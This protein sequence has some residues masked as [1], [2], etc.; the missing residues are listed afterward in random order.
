MRLW[1]DCTADEKIERWLNVDRVLNELTPHEREEYW[2]MSVFGARTAC[3]TIACAAG[4]CE[5]DDWFRAQGLVGLY[6]AESSWMFEIVFYHKNIV[7][8]ALLDKATIDG[9][10]VPFST[11]VMRFFGDIGSGQIFL[12]SKPRS[13]DAVIQEVRGFIMTLRAM[14]EL[15]S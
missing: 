7:V 3:G 5:R 9:Q 10:V 1:N 12:R 6:N 8:T 14:K 11:M 13:V 15:I 2:D 4:H